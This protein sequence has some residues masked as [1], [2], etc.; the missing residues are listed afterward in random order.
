MGEMP[1]F[2][3]PVAHELLERASH[4]VHV[5]VRRAAFAPR[6]FWTCGRI[7]V[8]SVGM[9]V[10]VVMRVPTW[11]WVRMAM[12]RGRAPLSISWSCCECLAVSY[13]KSLAC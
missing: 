7:G 12:R 11:V 13:D 4:F 1:Y 10:G 6:V 8:G 2:F 3:T 5:E 9:C